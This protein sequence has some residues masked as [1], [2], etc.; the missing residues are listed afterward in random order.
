MAEGYEI[1]NADE[2]YLH[3]RQEYTRNLLASIPKGWDA[4]RAA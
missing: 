2:I 3:P 1:A 4:S